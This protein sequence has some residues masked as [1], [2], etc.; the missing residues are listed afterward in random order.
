MANGNGRILS[1]LGTLIS[2]ITTS[3]RAGDW[4]SVEKH[5]HAELGAQARAG[6]RG[7]QRPK[8]VRRVT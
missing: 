7:A 2:I 5:G 3:D 1:P 8:S 6:E 4:R